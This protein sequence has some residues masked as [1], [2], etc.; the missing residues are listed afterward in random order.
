MKHQEI[1]K[2]LKENLSKFLS[3][4]GGKV[5]LE[6][7][8]DALDNLVLAILVVIMMVVIHVMVDV[9]KIHVLIV[10]ILLIDTNGHK[11]NIIW[12]KKNGNCTRI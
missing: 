1:S 2:E 8:M 3:L 12:R 4:K 10:I 5:D 6:L 9:T 7:I 11:I